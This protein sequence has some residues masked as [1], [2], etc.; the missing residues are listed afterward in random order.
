MANTPKPIEGIILH[1]AESTG[2]MVE[3]ADGANPLD[4]FLRPEIMPAIIKE[5]ENRA[6]DFVADLTTDKGRKAIASQAYKVAQTKTF[7]DDI[8]L[9]EVTKLK[10]M[11]KQVDSARKAMR[12]A[13]DKIKDDVRKP[14]TDWEAEQEKSKKRI[15]IMRNTPGDLFTSRADSVAIQTSID[16]L[17]SQGTDASEWGEFAG[18]A[19]STKALA[20]S[21]LEQM[22][23]E[24]KKRED[25]AKELERLRKEKA[26]RDAEE[27]RERLRKEGEERARKDMEAPASV[28]EETP[29]PA[30]IPAN[31]APASV[32]ENSP[33]PAAQ[34]YEAVANVEH[35]RQF[36]R[37]ALSDILPILAGDQSAAENILRAIVTGKIRHISITY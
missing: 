36:N 4:L 3:L 12:E 13:L 7:L 15:S 11:P 37:E 6:K 28:P 20:I 2:A 31:D 14:L 24:A 18:E 8:G 10:D 21:Q 1:P 32:K 25:D 22:L 35:R 29:A 30:P 5:V 23:E 26:E 9:R 34:T 17:T 27:E 19:S 33:S 16:T